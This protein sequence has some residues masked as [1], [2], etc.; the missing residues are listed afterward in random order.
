MTI[1]TGLAACGGGAANTT[2]VRVGGIAISKATVEH[3]ITVI[4]HEGAF[5]GY[6][7]E[8]V[9]TPEHRALALLIS[10]DG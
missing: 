10:S 5:T 6:R 3:W 1:A 8:A 7:G 9:G 2:V 4:K